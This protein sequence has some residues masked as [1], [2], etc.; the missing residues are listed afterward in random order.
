MNKKFINF[1]E[2]YMYIMGFVGNTIY[3]LQAFRIWQ[4]QSSLDVSVLGFVVSALSTWSWLGYG[5][6]TNHKVV[7]RINLYA[8]IGAIICL[9]FIFLYR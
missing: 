6:L 2:Y 9:T 4:T 8:S 5:Y 1:Y 3:L 7:F